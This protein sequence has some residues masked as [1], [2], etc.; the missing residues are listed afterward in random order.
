MN[1]KGKNYLISILLP[2]KNEESHLATVIEHILAN[3]STSIEVIAIN[4]HSTDKS[5]S[6][7]QKFSSTDSRFRLFDNE[8]TGL[9]EA[10]KTGYKHSTGSHI[11]RMDADDLCDVFKYAR[12]LELSEENTVVCGRVKY[13]SN[14]EL[15]DGFKRYGAWL[16]KAISSGEAW[17]HIYKECVVPSPSWLLRRE[18]LESIGGIS[19]GSY[20]EDYELA[21]RMYKQGFAIVATKEVVHLWQDHP[22]RNS[23]TNPHYRNHFFPSLKAK[24]FLELEVGDAHNLLVL[25]AGKRAKELVKEFIKLDAQPI[26][27]TDNAKKVGKDI[28]GIVLEDE[29]RYNFTDS[30]RI[31]IVV[32]NDQERLEVRELLEQNNLVEGQHFWFFC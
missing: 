30:D 2:F 27:L 13:F 20:P 11:S 6:I 1:L 18:D 5:K 12:M 4:D 23:R 17:K 15:Q 31:A 19:D 29:N 24:Y 16:N 22:Q 3:E 8:Q 28:Y 14:T 9:V 21:F 10:L 32:S 7:A 25:G 26:W